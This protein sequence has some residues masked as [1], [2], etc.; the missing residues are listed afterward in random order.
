[1]GTLAL[2]AL[3]SSGLDFGAPYSATA[4]VR[5]LTTG[6]VEELGFSGWSAQNPSTEWIDA[7]GDDVASDYEVQLVQSTSSGSASRVGPALSTYH[8]IS[9]T[10]AW[11]WEKTTVGS[12]T[13]TGT[14]YIRE[15]ADTSNIV[16]ATVFISLEVESGF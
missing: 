1:M 2:T 3:S 13:W 12:F 16:S 8:T 9:S 10:R 14:M 11:T 4:G 5:V 6:N 15:I 7:F